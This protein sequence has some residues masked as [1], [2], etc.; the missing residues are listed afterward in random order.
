V[1]GATEDVS[2]VVLDLDVPGRVDDLDALPAED[3]A[4]AAHIMDRQQRQRFLAAR[5]EIRLELGRIL[6]LS[7]AEVPFR[8]GRNGKPEVEGASV[9]FSV[10]SRDAACAMAICPSRPVGVELAR[11]P[12]CTP[13]PLLQQILPTRARRAVL[14]ADP[15]KQPR[16]FAL[17]WCRVEAAVRACGAGLNEADACLDSAPQEARGVGPSLVAAVALAGRTAPLD[18]RWY[19]ET[20]VGAA[21]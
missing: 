8:R 10:A 3:L 6:G 19:M 17:W 1:I 14:A 11:V 5:R 20:P 4:L 9:H 13:V 15:N 16:E 7:P 18:V 21:W 12:E 2:V